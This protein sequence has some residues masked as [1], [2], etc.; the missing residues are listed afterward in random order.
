[1]TGTVYLL[2]TPSGKHYIGITTRPIEERWKEHQKKTSHCTLVKRAISKYGWD[3]LQK[4][5]ILYCNDDQLDEYETKFI[6]L[7][8]C[9]A[10]N[11]L[12][13]T[14]GGEGGKTLSASTRNNITNGMKKYYENNSHWRKGKSGNIW[15]DQIRQR[16]AHKYAQKA[17]GIYWKPCKQKYEVCIP[18]SWQKNANKKYQYVGLFETM[19]LAKKAQSEWLQHSI[20]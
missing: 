20:E 6:Q 7:Y 14:T 16:V 19:E 1:M 12:N 11:G 18:R 4:K 3:N 2:T 9:L 10:P 8:N 13:C 15:S 17:T 5:I